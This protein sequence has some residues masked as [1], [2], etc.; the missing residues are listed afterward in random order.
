VNYGEHPQQKFLREL[1]L[2]GGGQFGGDVG[3]LHGDVKDRKTGGGQGGVNKCVPV[4][5]GF[6]FV[7][8]IVEFDDQHGAEFVP[9]AQDE[10]HMLGLDAIEVRL[11]VGCSLWHINEVGQSDLA[12]HEQLAIQD[13]AQHFVKRP[14]SG[15]EKIVFFPVGQVR[16]NAVFRVWSS[17]F[18][19]SG[20]WC[21]ICRGSSIAGRWRTGHAG[22]A[23]LGCADD[24]C[25][26]TRSVCS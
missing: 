19:L 23:R 24:D 8:R 13:T 22:L 15:G 1:L 11:P 14:L 16:S 12:E 18:R 21:Q 20:A 17:A 7:R 4:T 25:F 3:P 10:I 6:F 9:S 26:G 5:S 2:D